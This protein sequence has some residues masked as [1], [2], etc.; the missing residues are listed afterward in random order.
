M[1]V[2][3]A[4]DSVV[5]IL[6]PI[7]A[8]RVGN[9]RSRYVHNWPR[10]D[11][12]TAPGM[13]HAD[14]QRAELADDT[15]G[16]APTRELASAPAP[17]A[18]DRCTNCRAPLAH[19]QRYCV[20]C[21]ERRGQSRFPVAQPVTE[22]RTRRTRAVRAAPTSPRVSSGTTLVAGIGVL[23]LAIGLGVLIGSIAKKNNTSTRAAAPPQVIFQGGSSGAGTASVPTSRPKTIHVT[24]KGQAKLKAAAKASAPPP[25][26]VQKKATQAA[27]KVLGSSAHLAPPTV[28]TGQKCSSSQ[29]GCSGGT[30]NGNFFG[31]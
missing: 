16:D 4:A 26:A 30:F 24:A 9:Y 25:A 23:L 21:G 11:T 29:A 14:F 7:A 19:D 22:V 2:V 15:A 18:E 20:E 5:N 1:S 3:S 31:Q 8:R 10:A 17:P 27:S 12:D 13:G 28:T 6:K